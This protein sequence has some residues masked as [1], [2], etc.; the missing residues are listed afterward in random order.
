ML[1]RQLSSN[2]SS[3]PCGARGMRVAA[4]C[5]VMSTDHMVLMVRVFF[6]EPRYLQR[7]QS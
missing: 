4:V 3:W 1:V 2:C 7:E 5:G 6:L